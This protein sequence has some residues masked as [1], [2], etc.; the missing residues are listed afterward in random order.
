MH[1][2]RIATFLALTTVLSACG[3]SSSNN[4]TPVSAQAANTS[5][6]VETCPYFLGNTR[7]VAYGDP[8]VRADGNLSAK[9][10]LF[11]MA[12]PYKSMDFRAAPTEP[13]VITS[14]DMLE[15]LPDLLASKNQNADYIVISAGLY[16]I[17]KDIKPDK[18]LKNLIKIGEQI[19]ESGRYP[20][21]VAYPEIDGV[22]TRLLGDSWIFSELKARGFYVLEGPLSK[23]LENPDFRV[24]SLRPNAEG[25]K[26]AG[27]IITEQFR[28]CTQKHLRQIAEEHKRLE[29][30]RTGSAAQAPSETVPQ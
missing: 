5:L 6:H 23:A 12:D 19:K 4:S 2:I 22:V 3:Q 8:V 20:I 14:A 16:D 27:K 10:F 24:D 9:P 29:R 15:I 17:S 25:H 13:Q 7:V 21:F 28:K 1:R 26:L 18:S 30:E 11:Y